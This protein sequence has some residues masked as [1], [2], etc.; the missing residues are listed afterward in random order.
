MVIASN[1]GFPRIGENRELK[2]TVEEYWKG[3]LSE[4]ELADAADKIKLSNYQAQIKAGIEHIPCND[5][6][7]YDQTLDLAFMLDVIPERFRNSRKSDLEIYFDMARGNE[8]SYACEMTKW[9]DTNYHYIVPE[10]SGIFSL[11]HNKPLNEFNFAKNKLGIIAKPVIIGPFTFLKLSRNN[12]LA[13]NM[14]KLVPIYSQII[15]SLSRAGAE[16]IQVDEPLLVKNISREEL[17][18]FK[19]AWKQIL[20]QKINSNV[21][22]QTYFEDLE[23]SLYKELTKLPFNL[24]GIDLVW[25]EN[26]LKTIKKHKLPPNKA[27][28]LGIV[29]G[30]NIWASDIKEAVQTIKSLRPFVNIDRCLLQPSCSLLHLPYTVKNETDLNPKI[31]PWLAFAKERLSEIRLIADIINNGEAKYLDKIKEN[32]HILAGKAKSKLLTDRQVA[33]RIKDI[34]PAMFCRTHYDKRKTKQEH[35]LKLPLLPT[36]TIG[37]F[38]QT[39]EVRHLRAEFEN[40]RI[41]AD[42]YQEFINKKIEE[43]INLQ[44]E[45]GLDVLVHGE[46]ERSDMVAFFGKQLNGMLFTENGWVQS[47]G[48]RCVKPPVIYGDIS[49]NAPMTLKETIYAQS[50]TDKIVKGMLTGPITIIN[51]SFPR[52][53]V[54]EKTI[55]FQLAL[56]LRDEITDLENNGIKIIQIDEAAFREGLPLKHNKWKEY[57]SWAVKAFRLATAGVKDETQIHTHMCYSDFNDIIG[58]I[59]EMDADVISIED[60]RSGGQLLESFKNFKYDRG[61]GPGVYDIHSPRIASQEEITAQIQRILQHINK[62]TLWIN[63]DCGLKTRT[64]KETIPSLR[65]MVSA[66]IEM[67]DRLT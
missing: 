6:S 12:N 23:E 47:Y 52:N 42:A 31:K 17:S 13:E 8:E 20:S 2:K 63:P 4:S 56:V 38:P 36:T 65:N 14:E 45:I 33:K 35:L 18:I 1:I 21:I 24:I 22:I 41:S 3:K 67:R 60:S 40:G 43:V 15:A 29:D 19:K 66:A 57:L 49:R 51:W 34:K 50:I 61:I 7:L 28:A 25:G 9:F 11:R 10:I 46:F 26:N 62:Q 32:S 54:P 5:F 48:S 16:Y 53:D 64:Y 39:S 30:R 58:S 37:S 44:N 27:L 59:Y 55:A